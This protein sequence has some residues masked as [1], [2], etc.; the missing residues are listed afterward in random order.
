MFLRQR[1]LDSKIFM[2]LSNDFEKDF[3]FKCVE[4]P[5]DV[6][7]NEFLTELRDSSDTESR[8]LFDVVRFGTRTSP[9]A[10]K[11]VVAI[12]ALDESGVCRNLLPIQE[13]VQQFFR[14]S[15]LIKDPATLET[16][17]NHRAFCAPLNPHVFRPEV[18]ERMANFQP[19]WVTRGGCG[20]NLTNGNS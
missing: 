6:G 3:H 12:R 1:G 18:Q 20:L 19:A 2:V 13:A 9:T 8:K 15:K 16:S 5:T 14:Q 7:R 11:L 4:H 17:Y 10:E